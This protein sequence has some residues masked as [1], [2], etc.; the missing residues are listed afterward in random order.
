MRFPRIPIYSAST[1]LAL[2]RRVHPV[3][4]LVAG[5]G[6]QVDPELELYENIQCRTGGFEITFD[7]HGFKNP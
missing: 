4:P 6:S 2:N 5:R 7:C 3:L 1:S